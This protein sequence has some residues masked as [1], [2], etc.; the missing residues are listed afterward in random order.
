MKLECSLNELESFISGIIK[1]IKIDKEFSGC[2]ID[3]E[4][5]DKSDESKPRPYVDIKVF[6]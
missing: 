4:V 2:V 6:K 5:I 3:I 1:G